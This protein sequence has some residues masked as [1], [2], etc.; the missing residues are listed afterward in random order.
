[1]SATFLLAEFDDPAALLDAARRSRAAGLRTLR[2]LG[3]RL[4]PHVV[5]VSFNLTDADAVPLYRVR[6]LVRLAAERAGATVRR[7]ELIGLTLADV[8]L[9][10]TDGLHIRLRSSKTD[11][12]GEGQT[13]AIPNGN[14][15]LPVA[16]LKAWLAVRPGGAGPLFT[17]ASAMGT[18]TLLP[19]SDRA[20]ARI[21][22]KYA[23]LAGLDASTLA[24]RPPPAGRH[25][26]RPWLARIATSSNHQGVS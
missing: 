10:K 15:I 8:T 19:M 11:Q 22:Q 16:R 24:A 1:M 9:H 5:Q 26:P 2:A 7:S 4:G 23:A 12:D 20:I 17:H 13:I 18:M 25:A 21:V 6:E 3:I 14:A